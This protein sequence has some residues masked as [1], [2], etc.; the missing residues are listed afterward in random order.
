M[1]MGRYSDSLYFLPSLAKQKL[2]VFS[3]IDPTFNLG[4]TYF[5]SYG[6]MDCRIKFT[7]KLRREQSLDKV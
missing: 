4:E 1:R 5:L 3:E 6:Y 7:L 2:E